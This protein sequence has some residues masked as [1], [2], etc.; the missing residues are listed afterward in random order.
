MRCGRAGITECAD[1]RW[2]KNRHPAL[3]FLSGVVGFK[4][5]EGKG[6]GTVRG[7]IGP[8]LTTGVALAA[9][10][11]VVANPIVAPRS[12][13]QIPAVE[14]SAGSG[15]PSGM[16][17][18]DFLDAIAPSPPE[19]TNPFSVLRQLITSLAADATYL[20]KN[21]IVDAFVAGVTAVSQPELTAASTP[22]YPSV[23]NTPELAASVLPGLDL[24][25]FVPLT[26]LGANLASTSVVVNDAVVPVVQTLVTSVVTDAGYVGGQLVAAAFVAGAVAVAEP[27][28]IGDTLEALIKGDLNGALQSAVKVMTAP[29]APSIVILN[30]L[31]A[32]V[33]KNIIN[34]TAVLTDTVPALGTVLTVPALTVPALPEPVV[35]STPAAVAPVA[36]PLS[37]RGNASADDAEVVS[38][39]PGQAAETSE[40]PAA[41]TAATSRTRAAETA[42]EPAAGQAVPA[43]DTPGT[44]PAVPGGVLRQAV[45]SVGEQIGAALASP[46]AS[47]THSRSAVTGKGPVRARG[48]QSETA[49]S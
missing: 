40:S 11:V 38:T 19:S 47:A 17:D 37:G 16:L 23:A 28:L 15:D 34:V 14:L 41:I 9:A 30:A 7:A 49:A 36:S 20:G 12:D 6:V 48:G 8:I 39:E 27:A 42:D 22:Y 44:T 21:A 13:V 10:G 25:T 5:Q 33:E 43:G 4:S 26:D 45:E 3:S 31:R 2:D 29:L 1:T 18:Q 24:E 46:A 35:V 32:V